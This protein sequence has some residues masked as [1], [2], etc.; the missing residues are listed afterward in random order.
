MSSWSA[1]K[2]CYWVC[3]I[4]RNNH[5]AYVYPII[6]SR[7]F[8]CLICKRLWR[9]I[10]WLYK[11][12]LYTLDWISFSSIHQYTAPYLRIN[13]ISIM[14]S[15]GLATFLIKHI[16]DVLVRWMGKDSYKRFRTSSSRWTTRNWNDDQLILRQIWPSFDPCIFLRRLPWWFCWLR[17]RFRWII[18]MS[19]HWWKICC[20]W[21]WFLVSPIMLTQNTNR[22]R[23]FTGTVHFIVILSNAIYLSGCSSLESNSYELWKDPDILGWINDVIQM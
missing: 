16:L 5:V 15:H 12:I 19:R 2:M 11:S 17:R 21:C 7:H 23:Y 4:S 22:V 10:W 6:M 9:I 1:I 3:V 14:V 20:S 8:R 18:N 13:L